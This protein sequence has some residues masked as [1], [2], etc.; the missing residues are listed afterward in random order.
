VVDVPNVLNQ[1]DL[2]VIA[3]ILNDLTIDDTLNN[4]FRDAGIITGNQVVVGVLSDQTMF[5][6]ADKA[7]FKKAKKK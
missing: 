3:N 5:Y 7:L 2:T 4:L 6:I 1:N